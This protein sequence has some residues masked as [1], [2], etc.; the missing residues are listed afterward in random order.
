MNNTQC[1]PTN[2]KSARQDYIF[3]PL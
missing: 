2:H 1:N 3:D